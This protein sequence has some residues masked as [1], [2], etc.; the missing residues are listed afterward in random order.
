LIDVH[1]VTVPPPGRKHK[2]DELIGILVMEL[3][4]KVCRI[5]CNAR[6]VKQPIVEVP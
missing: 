1:F 2:V 3:W 4:T 6:V 5:D